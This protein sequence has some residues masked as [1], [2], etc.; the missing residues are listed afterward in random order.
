MEDLQLSDELNPGFVRAIETN[1]PAFEIETKNS[2]EK[3]SWI[4]YYILNHSLQK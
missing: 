4:R 2:T 3:I 1:L